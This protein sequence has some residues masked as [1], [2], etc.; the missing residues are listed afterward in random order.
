M[1]SS[2]EF[3][4]KQKFSLNC[5]VCDGRY[6]RERGIDIY[7]GSVCKNRCKFCIA[8][9]SDS[10]NGS[11]MKW[12]QEPQ[13][14]KILDTFYF[15]TS[16]MS[17]KPHLTIL[18][19]E[20]MLYPI[21]LV[22][23]LRVVRG[24]VSMI[25]LQ[26]SIPSMV[27][28]DW[29]RFKEVFE[30]IDE[31]EVSIHHPLQENNDKILNSSFKEERFD[32][33]EVIQKIKAD[34]PRLR[35]LVNCVLD[36]EYW[37][38]SEIPDMIAKSELSGVDCL[39]LTEVKENPE[40]LVSIEELTGLKLKS[41]YSHGCEIPVQYRESKMEIFFRINCFKNNLSIE[42]TLLDMFKAFYHFLKRKVCRIRKYGYAIGILP[43]GRV[44]NKNKT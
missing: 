31:L 10:L 11:L 9:T 5:N 1:I 18:G 13:L 38:G 33:F 39:K 43:D 12:N 42:P 8:K 2:K 3:S 36:K 17:Y 28:E 26:T 30:S 37:H 19:G 4:Y 44:L 22:D 7:L 16:K 21:E 14:D 25:K 32:R 35:V 27:K 20:P 15:L 23:L 34:F 24:K 29:N 41:G 6:D 40:R